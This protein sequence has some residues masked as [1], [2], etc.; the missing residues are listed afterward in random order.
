M[1]SCFDFLW[2]H[3]DPRVDAHELLVIFRLELPVGLRPGVT[4]R[5]FYSL[6]LN[7]YVK[8]S[9]A[10]VIFVMHQFVNNKANVAPEYTMRDYGAFPHLN[11]Q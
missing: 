9:R 2:F 6:Y 5:Y 1:H 4:A 10:F 11:I 3:H 7:M 8:S